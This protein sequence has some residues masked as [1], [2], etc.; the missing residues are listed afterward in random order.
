MRCDGWW[1]GVRGAGIKAGESGLKMTSDVSSQTAPQFDPA[2]EVPDEYDVFCEACGYSLAGLSNDRCPECGA[3]FEPKQ[4]PFARIPWLHRK[5]LGKVNAYL[6]TV[7]MACFTP[8]RFARELC[9]PVRVSAADAR[10]FRL[11][12]IWMLTAIAGLAAVAVIAEFA[13]GVYRSRRLVTFTTPVYFDVF[14]LALSAL[15]AVAAFHVFLRLATDMPLFIWKGHPSLKPIE[16]SPVHQ[17]ACAPM[18]FAP[19][20]VGLCVFFVI[21]ADG[22]V[23]EWRAAYWGL[24]LLSAVAAPIWLWG[25]ALDLMSVSSRPSQQRILLMAVYL[26]LHWIIMFAMSY[27]LWMVF[28]V[29]EQSAVRLLHIKTTIF[30]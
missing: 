27:M 21:L 24:A 25:V 10:K 19:L 5:R 13:Y 6:R 1:V 9:R 23:L 12:T 17:Y 2:G 30:R 7:L 18:A 8:G 29:C 20:F 11:A 14:F 16:L 26:P 3:V 22:S 15:A 4:L 28:I